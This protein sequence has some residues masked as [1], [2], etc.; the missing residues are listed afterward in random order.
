M[1]HRLRGLCQHLFDTAGRVGQRKLWGIV[2]LV[3]CYPRRLIES[4]CEIAMREGVPSYKHRRGILVTSNRVVQDW[5]RY[6]RD[7]T[8]TSTILDRFLH[9]SK[10]LEFEGNSYR[11]REAAT[12]LAVTEESNS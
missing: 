11:L 2:G 6:L 10:L 8:M 9:R 1:D 3:R 5:G 4:A 7:S 12:R